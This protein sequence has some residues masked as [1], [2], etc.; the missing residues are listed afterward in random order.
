[1]KCIKRGLNNIQIK[2]ADH[3]KSPLIS[4]CITH[5]S[6][7]V[8][9]EATKI[10][11]KISLNKSGQESVKQTPNRAHSHVFRATCMFLS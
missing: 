3:N 8:I 5:E 7:R 1:M 10:I 4:Q 6:D 9:L 2:I 11:E